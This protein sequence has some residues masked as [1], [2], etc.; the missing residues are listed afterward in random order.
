MENG[1][2]ERRRN[3]IL[4]AA[5][6][7]F[8]R[9]G[10][11]AT[12]IDAVARRAGIGKSTVYEYFPSKEDLFVAAGQQLIDGILSTLRDALETSP[13]IREVMTRYF[14]CITDLNRCTAA[15][16]STLQNGSGIFERMQE[17]AMDFC[18]Q[19]HGLLMQA[20]RAAAERGEIAPDSDLE[21]AS[22]I[23]ISMP[24]PILAGSFRNEA[25]SF[26]KV[27]D[28]LMNALQTGKTVRSC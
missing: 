3:E 19:T 16:L 22:L 8:S 1:I 25:E 20:L 18:G 26:D 27:V 2:R 12:R 23:M 28:F 5:I 10:F 24:G 7:E 14:R 17:L 15:A 9:C 6:E 21:T 4:K 13:T 11:D